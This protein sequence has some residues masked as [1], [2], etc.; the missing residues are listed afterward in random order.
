FWTGATA[1][2]VGSLAGKAVLLKRWWDMLIHDARAHAKA[3]DPANDALWRYRAGLGSMGLAFL[4]AISN[5]LVLA[6]QKTASWVFFLGVAGAGFL[7]YRAQLAGYDPLGRVQ[8]IWRRVR[9]FLGSCADRVSAMGPAPEA[10]EG[11]NAI[12]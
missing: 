5:Q 12:R 9:G 3:V 11:W 7:A 10:L 8:G 2:D 4:L 6:H 1:V